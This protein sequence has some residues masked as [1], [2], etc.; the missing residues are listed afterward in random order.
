MDRSFTAGKTYSDSKVTVK[1][2]RIDP[3]H[4]TETVTITY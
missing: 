4:S 3:A 1:V 2:D